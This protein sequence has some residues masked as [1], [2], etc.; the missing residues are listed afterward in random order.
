MT[1]KD[2]KKVVAGGC[3]R[4]IA[5]GLMALLCITMLAQTN[6]C[7]S[8]T[9][10]PTRE[11][12]SEN[13]RP[14]QLIIPVSLIAAGSFGISN[15]WFCNAKQNLKDDFDDWRGDNRFKADEYLRY[16]PVASNIG[17][18]YVGVKARHPLRERLAA[19]ATASV[20]MAV[21]VN[22]AKYSVREKRP[23]CDSRNSFPSGHTATA[24]M[25]AELVREEYG[26]AYG[27]GAYAVATGVAFLRLYNNRHWLND[28]VGGAGIGILSARI[29]YWLLP[30]ERRL[31]GWDSEKTQLVAMPYYDNYDKSAGATLYV[32]F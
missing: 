8:M 16:L 29:G 28:V 17:L 9:T 22:I 19:T 12:S 1:H 15:N 20:V 10:I 21:S 27:A 13:F 31:F 25:G 4:Y 26:N 18:E 2:I 6:E 24:F 11:I 32:S 30:Y 14:Q 3:Q 7:D 5:T 23:D